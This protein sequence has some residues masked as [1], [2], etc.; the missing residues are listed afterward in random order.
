MGVPLFAW[1]VLAE[2]R[3]ALTKGGCRM[4][5][6]LQPRETGAPWL[7]H[8]PGYVPGH[9]NY[10]DVPVSWFL[11]EAARTHPQRAAYRYCGKT[12]SYQQL[13]EDARR[14]ANGLLQLGVEPGDRVGVLLPTCPQYLMAAYGIWLAGGVVVTLS[15]LSV[16]REISGL[17]TATDCRVVIALDLLTSRVTSENA[18]PR[19]IVE[20]TLRHDLPWF[21]RWAYDAARLRRGVRRATPPTR[22]LFLTDLM[23][24]ADTNPRVWS[25]AG[26]DP[27]YILP[28]GGTTA[29]PKAVVLSHRNLVANAW[30]LVHW[31]GKSKGRETILAVLP[32]FHSYGLSTCV[33]GGIA[34]AAT[35]ILSHR[36]HVTT[37]LRLIEQHRPTLF[38]AVPTM[39]AAMN[40]ELQRR[41]ADL[42]SLK[43]CISGGDSLS[44]D[45]GDAFA[46]FSGAEVVEGYGLSEASPV[47]HVGPLDGTARPGTIGFPLPDTEAR[48]VDADTGLRQ[49]GP[50][51]VGELIVRGPQVMLGYWNKPEET[52][53]VLRD[54]WLY[55]GD[56]A[57]YDEEG[58]FRIVDR[59]KDIII[60]SGFNVYPSDVEAVV[61]EFP[62]VADAAVVGVPYP[63]RGEVVKAVLVM[64]PGAE[65]SRPAFE[66]FLRKNLATY[67]RPKIVEIREGELPRNFLGKV[68]RRHLR[69]TAE[70]GMPVLRTITLWE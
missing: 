54:G 13:L 4:S 27:A 69:E 65:F 29:D 42:S 12:R 61:R 38:L 17:L 31:I 48:V 59:K 24:R 64:C 50:G 57:T 63:Q 22:R 37:V 56:L 23:K 52:R 34:M 1:R 16:G 25:R 28:T 58:F 8:Y 14:V 66:R 67:K 39:L 2:F 6:D 62:E 41:P 33:T 35:L 51:E 44:Q 19:T 5:I 68:L 18:A 30:Q 20:A 53:R 15:P 32:F 26:H 60:T 40:E 3:N 46:E 43:W 9:L 45:I 55:T 21:Q 49:L 10:P 36:F 7:E 47:T 11:E 70:D